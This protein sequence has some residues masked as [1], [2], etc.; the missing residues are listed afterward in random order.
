MPGGSILGCLIT[1]YLAD[2]IGRKKSIIVA[3]VIWVI[4]SILQ[5]AS[6]NRAMLVIGRVI[7]GLSVSF[8][9]F[10]YLADDESA[11]RWSTKGACGCDFKI[12]IS[13]TTVPLY[14]AEIAAPAVRGRMISLQQ[15]A[16]TWGM[17]VSISIFVYM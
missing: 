13:S 12:G 8:F 7:S 2:K 4:G 5:A 6:V 1:G 15:W 14:Q 3:G 11:L 17:Y 16:L 10:W 9:F